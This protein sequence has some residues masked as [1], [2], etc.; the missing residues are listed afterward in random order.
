MKT[1]S[2]ELIEKFLAQNN[3]PFEKIEE[4]TSHRPDYLITVGN[5]QLMF[6]VKELVKDKDFGVVKDLS[7]PH[8]TKCSRT[9]GDHVRRRI[10]GSK[11]QIQYGANHGIP[12]ILIIY[13]SL[14]PVF[15]AF[16]TEDMDFTAAML[17]CMVNIPSLS[18]KTL[19]RHRIGSIEKINCSKRAIRTH[20]SARWA[21]CATGLEKQR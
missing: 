21:A 20:L 3:V 2:E 11:K 13:N 12:S 9:V 7:M 16:G 19:E 15:Q 17:P 6:E 18:T 1:K 4:E 14:D 10:E 8:I 5:L